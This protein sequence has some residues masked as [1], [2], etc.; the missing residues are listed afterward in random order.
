[1]SEKTGPQKNPSLL[2]YS[3]HN[4]IVKMCVA[5]RMFLKKIHSESFSSYVHSQSS[6]SRCTGLDTDDC[7]S[8]G[9]V[10][11]PKNYPIY[12]DPIYYPDLYPEYFISS[13]KC[14][15]WLECDLDDHL[16]HVCPSCRNFDLQ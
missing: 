11:D 2:V 10:H 12:Y 8:F 6:M 1:M 16:V 13:T 14:A 3:G 9:L 15:A 4:F 5:M 7:P